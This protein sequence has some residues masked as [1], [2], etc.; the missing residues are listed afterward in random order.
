ML[1]LLRSFIRKGPEAPAPARDLAP[2]TVEAAGAEPFV[3][4]DHYA[5]PN[6][7]GRRNTRGAFFSGRVVAEDPSL[8]IE[9]DHTL[10]WREPLGAIAI[11]LV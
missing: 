6:R 8:K 5:F 1:G 3:L 2:S 10:D 7:G 9:A 11:L 4:A